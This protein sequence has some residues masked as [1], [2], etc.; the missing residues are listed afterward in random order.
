MSQNAENRPAERKSNDRSPLGSSVGRYLDPPATSVPPKTAHY[1]TMP[2]HFRGY[3]GQWWNAPPDQIAHAYY[4]LLRE[5]YEYGAQDAFRRTKEMFAA[6]PD[7]MADP[8]GTL[9]AAVRGDRGE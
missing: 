9:R 6:Y 5:V 1:Q 7:F 2:A 4:R 8:I 3:P